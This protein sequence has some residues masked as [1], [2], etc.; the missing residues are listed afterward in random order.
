ME[1]KPEDLP[2]IVVMEALGKWSVSHEKANIGIK[3]GIPAFFLDAGIFFCIKR[4]LL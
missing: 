3:Y 2:V 4:V 1:E